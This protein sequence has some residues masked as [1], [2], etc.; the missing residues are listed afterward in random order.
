[1]TLVVWRGLMMVNNNQACRILYFQCEHSV[2]VICSSI[3]CSQN[4]CHRY[5]MILAV[6]AKFKLVTVCNVLTSISCNSVVASMCYN[7]WLLQSSWQ[8][9]WQQ[10]LVEALIQLVER[11]SA[12]WHYQLL[13]NCLYSSSGIHCGFGISPAPSAVWEPEGARRR[14]SPAQCTGFS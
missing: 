1:M 5:N 9:L 8:W 12:L 14:V 11:V 2:T 3:G 10:V 4:I 6:V 13:N 7:N